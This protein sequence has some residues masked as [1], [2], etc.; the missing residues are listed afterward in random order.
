MNNVAKLAREI[1]AAM[2][3]DEKK[4]KRI[5]VKELE[6]IF[7]AH[8][9]FLNPTSTLS[10]K[11]SGT[12]NIWKFRFMSDNDYGKY[13]REKF[14]E[15]ITGEKP[16][17]DQSGLY[18]YVQEGYTKKTEPILNNFFKTE[19][20]KNDKI[21]IESISVILT[22]TSNILIDLKVSLKQQI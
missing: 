8:R 3:P 2:E 20:G 18:H 6:K 7:R 21:N 16:T 4:L 11:D 15:K 22:N 19:I 5:L 10:Y 14:V 9:V 17:H 12:T 13:D 1:L